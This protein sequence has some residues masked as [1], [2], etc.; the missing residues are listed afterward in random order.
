MGGWTRNYYNWLTASFGEG[1]KTITDT[2]A[3]TSYKEPLQVR[4]TNGSW[5]SLFAAYHATPTS[6]SYA[7]LETYAPII[8]CP[9]AVLGTAPSSLPNIALCLSYNSEREVGEDTYEEYTYDGTLKNSSFTLSAFNKTTTYNDENHSYELSLKITVTNNTTVQQT[10]NEI[11][12]IRHMHTTNST[13]Q[14]YVLVYKDIIEPISVE[15]SESIVV[16]LKSVV[17]IFNYTPYPTA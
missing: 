1:N 12:L 3:P 8:Q 15:A 2:G 6:S 9:S 5:K 11:C 17:P 10:I 14:D 16:E 4:A 13:G 7:G